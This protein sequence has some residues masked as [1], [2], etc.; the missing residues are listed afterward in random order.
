MTPN[1]AE[2][3]TLYSLREKR[4]ESRMTSKTQKEAELGLSFY[5]SKLCHLSQLLSWGCFVGG[6]I[7][8]PR[9]SFQLKVTFDTGI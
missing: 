5:P 8:H 1:S 2:L 7:A 4:D 6:K 9:S 3:W